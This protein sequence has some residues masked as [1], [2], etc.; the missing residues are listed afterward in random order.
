MKAILI[1]CTYL[2]AIADG[3]FVTRASRDNVRHVKRKWERNFGQGLTG[4]IHPVTKEFNHHAYIKLRGGRHKEEH[5]GNT[6]DIG[7]HHLLGAIHEMV[8]PGM[9]E[10]WLVEVDGQEFDRYDIVTALYGSILSLSETASGAVDLTTGNKCFLS[11]FETIYQIDM[12][13]I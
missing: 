4:L 5:I 9:K 10:A 1:L 2:L 13:F 6:K 12:L 11:A 7:L 3:R 8:H